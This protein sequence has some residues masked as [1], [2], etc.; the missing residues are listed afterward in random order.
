MGAR[1]KAAVAESTALTLADCVVR[2]A[3]G[4]QRADGSVVWSGVLFVRDCPTANFSND[5]NGGCNK[6]QVR[7][8][9]LFEEFKALAVQVRPERFEQEDNL[10]GELWDAAMLKDTTMGAS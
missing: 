10:V 1:G 3:R 4:H 8:P 7:A 2:A 9:A 5:G 6:W